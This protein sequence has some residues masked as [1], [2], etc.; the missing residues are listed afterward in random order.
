MFRMFVVFFAAMVMF[1]SPTYAND[2]LKASIDADYE[3]LRALYEHLHTNPELSYQEKE[4]SI[5]LASE[6]RSLGFEVTE[7]VGGYGIVGVFE[8]GDGPTVMI[9][10]DMDGLPVEE[11]TGVV[12]ASRALGLSD[13]GSPV[14]VMHACGHDIHMTAFIGTA[15]RLVSMKDEWSGT[16]LM[17]GQPA[18]ERGAGARAMLEDGLF[19]RFPRPDY[20]LALHT[21]SSLAAG[22]V[23]VVEGWALANVDS[24]DITV[25]GIG[26]H[27][28]YP[29]TTKDPVVIA[30]QIVL[31]LQTIIS[32]EISPQEPAVITVGSFHAGLKHNIISDE[33]RLQLTVR[34]Y[35]DQVRQQLLSAI[36]RVAINVGRAAGLPDELLPVVEIRPEEYTPS[37]YNSPE[38]ARRVSSAIRAAGAAENVLTVNPVMGGEDFSRYGRE[39]PLIPSFIFW[40]GGV[41]RAEVARYEAGEISLPSLHSPFFAPVPEPTIKTGV[42]SMTSAALDLFAKP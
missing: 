7:S 12:Y 2:D 32:R 10:T 3:Y 15:R 6:L 11:M 41:D 36:E 33:A 26:G 4:T 22:D 23:G 25:R 35:T 42:A 37:T 28:A 18:E 5:R 31:A 27:G 9:R 20:N 30:S 16:L 34:S 13:D 29:H 14:P 21:N 8:N 39:E 17:I 1:A 24:I 40:L 19:E 38:L